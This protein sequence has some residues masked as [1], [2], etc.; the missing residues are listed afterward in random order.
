LLPDHST[1]NQAMKKTTKNN[2]KILG[3]DG[4]K[5]LKEDCTPALFF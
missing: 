4:W 3:R 2:D 5:E 1:A